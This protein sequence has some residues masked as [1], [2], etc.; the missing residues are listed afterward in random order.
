M[1]ALLAWAK[2]DEAA[3]FQTKDG[4]FDR[5]H[6]SVEAMQDR[7]AWLAKLQPTTMR[8]AREALNVVQMHW[9][10]LPVRA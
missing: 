9:I 7:A 10:G 6:A 5:P 1:Q 3:A 4:D 2:I 8:G